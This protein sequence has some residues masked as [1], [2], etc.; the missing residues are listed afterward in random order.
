MSPEGSTVSFR[1]TARRVNRRAIE[2][3][4]HRLETEVARG[5]RFDCLISGDAELRRLNRQ[6]RGKDQP[7][8]VLSFPSDAPEKRGRTGFLGDIAVSLAR[9]DSQAR[10]FGHSLE[11]EIGVLLLHGL[12]HLL[13][14]DH[15][16]DKG[17]MARAEKR[18]RDRLGLPSGLIERVPR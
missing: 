1:P 17:R 14:F 4:V 2:R 12:L 7:T 8:D 18:W 6:F 16:T 13:G 10:R 9:A 5:R 11:A 15:E 3:F